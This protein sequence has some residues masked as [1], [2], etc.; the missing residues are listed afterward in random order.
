MDVEQVLQNVSLFKE[1]LESP[2]FNPSH[3]YKVIELLTS[4]ELADDDRS[5]TLYR[6]FCEST[7]MKTSLRTTIIKQ[8][9]NGSK[10]SGTFLE[11]VLR[12]FSEITWR[13]NS[14]AD[15]R[16]QLPLVE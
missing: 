4:T 5:A 11:D 8:C 2:E 7:A 1:V 10:H 12:L 6:T 14:L 3:L 16:G 13:S 15:L 9:A